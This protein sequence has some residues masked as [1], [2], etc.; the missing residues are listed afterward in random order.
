MYTVE[1]AIAEIKEQIACKEKQ[2]QLLHTFDSITKGTTEDNYHA[3][4]NT[5]LRNSDVLGKILIQ[6]FP[7]LSYREKGCNYFYYNIINTDYIVKIPSSEAR[8]IEINMSNYI[9]DYDKI[10]RDIKNKFSYKR[11]DLLQKIQYCTTILNTK[12]SIKKAKLIFANYR[13]AVAVASYI[14]GS[15][16]TN[17]NNQYKAILA[18]LTEKLNDLNMAE[19]KYKEGET[20][21]FDRQQADIQKYCT[22]FLKWTDCVIIC[23]DNRMLATVRM[24]NNNIVIKNY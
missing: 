11:D 6:N 2:I 22:E 12:S 17:Y 18:Q 8:G 19:A 13:T 5:P 10:E 4:C 9:P 7:F 20:A 16:K 15:T 3:F 21:L 24:E 14:K 23:K 1:T